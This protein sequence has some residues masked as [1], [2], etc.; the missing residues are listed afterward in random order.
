M[1]EEVKPMPE[2]SHEGSMDNTITK[3]KGT[4]WMPAFIVV[5]L[6][7]VGMIVMNGGITGSTIISETEAGESLVAFLNEKTDGGV[8]LL[9][10]EKQDSLYEVT[11]S[12]QGQEIPVYMTADGKYFV[13]TAEEINPTG[14]TGTQN[15]VPPNPEEIA[16]FVDCLSQAEFKIYGA[17]WC[18]WTKKLVDSFGG[19]DAVEGIYVE[20]T[21]ETELCQAEG[22][23]GYPTIKVGGESYSGSRT[24]SDF[25]AA[26]GCAAPS[27]QYQTT[28]GAEASCS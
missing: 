23:E 24:F 15:V 3:Y 2:K 5:S 13:Q 28:D 19:F 8:T 21:E 14:E 12:Y 17:N 20:C 7:L 11:V 18:G 22:V 1:S 16:A 27:S 9:E 26:T 10:V 25:A 6:L 4:F